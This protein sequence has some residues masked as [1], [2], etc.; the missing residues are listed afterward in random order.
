M[1]SPSIYAALIAAFFL[2]GHTACFA[3]AAPKPVAVSDP[4][5]PV[6]VL[7]IPAKETTLVAQM[8]G[9]VDRLGGELG[10]SFSAGSVMVNLDCA[11]NQARMGMSQAEYNA[12]K[13]QHDTKLRLLAL[14]AAG[15]VEVQMAASAADKAR[16][17]IELNKAQMRLCVVSAPFAGRIVK[18]HVKQYQGVNV[19]QPI[20]DIVSAGPLK[21]RLNAPSKWLSWLKV[22]STFQINIDET[23][24]S[25][26]AKVTAMNGRVDAV[27]Q[28]IELEGMV[29]GAYKELLAGMS[30]NASFSPGK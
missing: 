6:R 13:E 22:G 21:V 9:R 25:Y 28:S 27:S 17:Q 10:G 19:G 29:M 8:V 3:Q 5:T 20:M 4:G 2:S 24:K 14:Q 23:G 18:L 15:E 11:E 1:H 26:A 7:L 12:A 30:G 16:A